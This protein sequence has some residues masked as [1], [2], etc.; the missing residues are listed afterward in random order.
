MSLALNE[1]ALTL[2]FVG[3]MLVAVDG[4]VV[5]C[6]CC[7]VLFGFIDGKGLSFQLL[8]NSQ[9]LIYQ[10]LTKNELFPLSSNVDIFYFNI[11]HLIPTNNYCATNV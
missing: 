11:K 7:C 8:Y 10:V 9:T 1:E 6:V 5:F 3:R 4:V 2:L